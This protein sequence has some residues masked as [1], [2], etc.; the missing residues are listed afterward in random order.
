MSAHPTL[1][2]TRVLIAEGSALL[3]SRLQRQMQ[4]MPG[5]VTCTPARSAAELHAQLARETFDLLLIDMF[6]PGG[7]ALE[8]LPHL[9]LP[10]GCAVI[11]LGPADC[12]ELFRRRQPDTRIQYIPK[13]CAFEQV[14]TMLPDH[15]SA[16]RN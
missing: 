16:T 3:S 7:A 8:L 10:P 11:V 15:V 13:C 5:T 9:L 6:L 12:Y 4:H 14:M 1:L 2:P